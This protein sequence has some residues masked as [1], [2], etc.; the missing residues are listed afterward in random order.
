VRVASVAS[1]GPDAPAS[2]SAAIAG[3]RRADLVV[4][5][6]G[7]GSGAVAAYD[8]FEVCQAVCASPSP[9]VVA[10]GHSSDASLA[11]ECAFASAATP[12]AAGELCVGLLGRAD[13]AVGD[14]VDDIVASSRACLDRALADLTDV[15]TAVSSCAAQISGGAARAAADRSRRHTRLALVAVVVL[16]VAVIA[17]LVTR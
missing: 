7:G 1:E 8:S 6:R 10:V 5:T 13:A 3:L 11:D 12:T 4:V 15:E 2:I 16:A 9:V 17:M 14:A